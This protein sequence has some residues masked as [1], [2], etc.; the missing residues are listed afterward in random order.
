MIGQ[1]R[2]PSKTSYLHW[3]KQFLSQLATHRASGQST[4][5]SISLENEKSRLFP[6]LV[7]AAWEVF[8]SFR[9]NFWGA[10]LLKEL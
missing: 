6:L 5:R 9:G 10:M 3:H 8:H 1:I 4:Q 7:T 2:L